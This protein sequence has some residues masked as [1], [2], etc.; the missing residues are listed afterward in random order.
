M[1]MI[2][3]NHFYLRIKDLDEL[4]V[5]AVLINAPYPLEWL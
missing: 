4:Y 1:M 5:N 3:Y 2:H